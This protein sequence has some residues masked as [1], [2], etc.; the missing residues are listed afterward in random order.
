MLFIILLFMLRELIQLI[1]IKIP[2]LKNNLMRW[3]FIKLFIIIFL[4][5]F[6]VNLYAQEEVITIVGDSLIGKMING[7]TVREVYGD[8]VIETGE[9]CC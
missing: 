6:S 9:C 1:K 4:G 5:Y 7:E 8:V 3:I 2:E